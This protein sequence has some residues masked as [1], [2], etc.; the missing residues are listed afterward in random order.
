MLLAKIC[1]QENNYYLTPT[2]PKSDT[3]QK[4][5]VIPITA[6]R[7]C[8]GF[9]DACLFGDFLKRD[10]LMMLKCKPA[11]IVGLYGHFLQATLIYYSNGRGE[12]DIKYLPSTPG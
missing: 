2:P 5:Q 6:P 9:G 1:I 11:A 3:P 8:M 10:G 4:Q 12:K 7:W